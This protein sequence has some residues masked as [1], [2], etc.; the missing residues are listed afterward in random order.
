M[1]LGKKPNA[2]P[3]FFL[4][5]NFFPNRFSYPSP[6]QTF[7]FLLLWRAL[8][9]LHFILLLRLADFTSIPILLVSIVINYAIGMFLQKQDKTV[10]Q[11]NTHAKLLLIFGLVLNM[12]FL[13]SFKYSDFFIMNINWATESSMKPLNILL[14]LAISF[15]TFHQISYLVDSYLGEIKSSGLLEYTTY[16]TFFPKLI[17]GPIVRYN[18]FSSQLK[19]LHASI[20]YRNASI[21]LLLFFVGLLKVTTEFCRV[22]PVCIKFLRG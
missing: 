12:V 16:I 14:P 15:F 22:R 6:V 17:S 11:G 18:E 4:Y 3:F 10:R 8:A 5:L 19:N 2:F 13:G 20:D 21:G 9:S 7:R 1:T